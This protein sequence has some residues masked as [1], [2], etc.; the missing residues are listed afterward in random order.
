MG[1]GFCNPVGPGRVLKGTNGNMGALEGSECLA[2]AYMGQMSRALKITS[3][4][5]IAPV[6]LSLCKFH[7]AN[8]G[9]CPDLVR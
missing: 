7:S 5:T 4:R 9:N 3:L 6:Q 8:A 2:E 1:E